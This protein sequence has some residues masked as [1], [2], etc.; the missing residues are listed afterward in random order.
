P[1]RVESSDEEDSRDLATHFN[2]MRYS[3]GASSIADREQTKREAASDA[4]QRR[5]G[6]QP[7]HEMFVDTSRIDPHLVALNNTNPRASQQ[8]NKLALS[9]ISRSAERGIK[10]ILIASAQKA[11]G[12]TTITLNLACALAR[13]RQRV[14]VVD[15]DLLNPSVMSMLGLRCQVGIEEAFTVGLAPGSAAVRIEPFGFNV[16]PTGR[17]VEN[18]V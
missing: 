16:L 13:A 5:S 18:H 11:E 3:M 7:A 1:A 17:P 9:V 15:C 2:F 8:Y 12:R 10:R 14:L 4:I 6:S